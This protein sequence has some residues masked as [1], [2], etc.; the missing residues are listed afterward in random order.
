MDPAD[1]EQYMDSA[2]EHALDARRRIEAAVEAGELPVW[3]ME[4]CERWEQAAL[5]Y[6]AAMVRRQM[7]AVS[8]LHLVGPA[9]LQ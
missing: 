3:V 2:A 8:S 6:G 9:T 7:S 5:A 4:A 1:T